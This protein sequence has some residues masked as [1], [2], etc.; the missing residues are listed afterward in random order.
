MT[1][2]RRKL[3]FER[4]LAR[5]GWWVIV[6]ALLIALAAACGIVRVVQNWRR[7][8]VYRRVEMEQAL[9]TLAGSLDSALQQELPRYCVGIPDLSMFSCVRV[10]ADDGTSLVPDNTRVPVPA[11]PARYIPLLRQ[12]VTD[13]R[14]AGMPVSMLTNSLLFSS[15]D[16]PMNEEGEFDRL[17]RL[18][19]GW[20]MA[21]AALVS[22]N[23]E[24]AVAVYQL[25]C[26]EFGG[27]CDADGFP[28][29]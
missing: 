22:N 12:R 18:E 26:K 4:R 28:T 10:T 1:G 11:G 7:G 29:D 25:L 17:L 13:I 5:R 2:R 21:A 8:D 16:M 20:R 6:C 3:S 9:G 24:R 15:S 19:L 27:Y 14:W 23:T